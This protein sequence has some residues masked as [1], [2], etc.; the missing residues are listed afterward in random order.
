M[1]QTSAWKQPFHLARRF[2]AKHWYR[3]F[4]DITTIAITG[5]FGKTSTARAIASVLSQV[6]QTL[7]TDLNLDT[8]YNLPITLL[9]IRHKHRKLIVELGVDHEGDMDLYLQLIK[10]RICVLTGIT[11]VHSD[12]GLL[13]SLEGVVNEKG[14]LL[15]ALPKKGLAILNWDDERVQKMARKTNARVIKYGIGNRQDVDYWA[16][17][18]K[19]TPLGTSF[20]LHDR[21]S[22]RDPKEI[23]LK[24][25]L[26]GSHFVHA[27]LVASI[28][29][30][31]QGISWKAISAGLARLKPLSGRVS[32]EEGPGGSVLIND[33]LRANPASTIAGLEVLASLPTKGKRIAILGEMGELG[34][35]AIKEHQEI[36]KKV[37]RLKIDA[38]VSVGPLQKHTAE[39]AIKGG[40]KKKAVYWVKD[41]Q[42][43]SSVLKQIL[44]KGD[45]FYLKGS[46]LRHMERILLLLKNRDVGCRI[47]SCSFYHQCSA[48]PY[49]K[50]GLK[51]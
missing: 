43:A 25:G 9:K 39:A 45:M 37:A 7:M 2:F 3:R 40:M 47:T 18:I 30:R 8:V 38:L 15:E 20:I 24:T 14:K 36:G 21:I 41:V 6:Y 49:L 1:A 44:K 23:K 19:I 17:N 29:G 34:R 31:F 5:S 42:E 13:G 16:S 32:L 46:L 4:S 35:Y 26:I 48:C 11:P 50:T 51:Y 22:K 28:I 10:P 33:A 27:C 12:P